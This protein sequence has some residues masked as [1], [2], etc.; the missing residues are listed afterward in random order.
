MLVTGSPTND[1]VLML[2]FVSHPQSTA[3]YKYLYFF[4]VMSVTVAE[5]AE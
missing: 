3:L 4:M 1:V 5:I 2:G